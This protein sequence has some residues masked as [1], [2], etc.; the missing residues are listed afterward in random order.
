MVVGAILGAVVGAIVGCKSANE[1]ELGC[2]QTI[3][4]AW[5]VLGGWLG[6]G[7]GFIAVLVRPIEKKTRRVQSRV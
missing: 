6:A 4:V 2:A 5:V 7:T 3:I 1:S